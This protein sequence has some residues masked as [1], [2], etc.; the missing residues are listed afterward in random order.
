MWKGGDVMEGEGCK[1]GKREGG[2]KGKSIYKR[3]GALLRKKGCG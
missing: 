3:I 2:K 1:E